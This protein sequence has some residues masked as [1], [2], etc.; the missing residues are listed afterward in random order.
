MVWIIFNVDEE[1]YILSCRSFADKICTFYTPDQTL[2]KYISKMESYFFS[3]DER[4]RAAVLMVA[5]QFSEG[6]KGSQEFN[7]VIELALQGA[8]DPNPMVRHA[9]AHTIGQFS[10]DMEASIK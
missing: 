4:W 2:K 5:S 9:A 8:K 1:E 7:K 10:E 3:K 6:Y